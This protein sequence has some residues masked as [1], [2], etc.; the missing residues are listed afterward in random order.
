MT[1][2]ASSRHPNRVTG[3]DT[4]T[5]VTAAEEL[6]GT[7][8]AGLRDTRPRT[9]A[10]LRDTV[11]GILEAGGYVAERLPELGPGDRTDFLTAAGIA[12]DLA[13]G[14]GTAA[15]VH[16]N[17]IRHAGHHQVTAVLVVTARQ[18]LLSVLPADVDGKPVR[19]IHVKGNPR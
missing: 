5:I 2:T 19:L 4:G 1:V 16:R 8:A 18:A 14:T 3:T 13:S 11:A 17:V 12:V 10:G 15:A 9:L 7:L 6:C